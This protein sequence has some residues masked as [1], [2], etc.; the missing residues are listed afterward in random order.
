MTR[1]DRR[2]FI[3]NAAIAGTAVAAGMTGEQALAGCSRATVANATWLSPR[4]KDIAKWDLEDFE[5]LVGTPFD[6]AG[7]LMVLEQIRLGPETPAEFR[8]QFALVFEPGRASGLESQM[9]PVRHPRLGQTDLFVN[10]VGA[11]T[12]GSTDVGQDAE[13]Y[14]S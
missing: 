14:F 5:P 8:K 6:I 1:I 10:I 3:Q 9:M 4:W 11:P 7:R 2:K 13:I 12:I